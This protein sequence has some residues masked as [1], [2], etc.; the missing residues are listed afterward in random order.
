M[1]INARLLSILGLIAAAI[2]LGGCFS[3]PSTWD[4]VAPWSGGRWIPGPCDDDR[5]LPIMPCDAVVADEW[6]Q[7]TGSWQVVELVDIALQNNPLTRQSWQTAKAAAFTWRASQSTLYP[8]VALTEEILLE[9]LSGAAFINTNAGANGIVG[10]AGVITGGGI[11]TTTGSSS[12]STTPTYNQWVLST[13][14]FSYLMLDF[15]GRSATIESARQA[16]LAA[17]WT[18]NRN[19]Q[20]IILN[21]L[22]DYYQHVQAKALFLAREDDLRNSLETLRSAEAQ[23]EFGIARI[24]DVLL[25][26]SNFANAELLLEQQR[27]MVNTTLGQLANSIGMPANT[28]FDVKELPDEIKL[29]QLQDNVEQLIE[30]AKRER[31]DLAATEAQWKEAQEN[32]I[33]IWSSG[34]PT[35]NAG[36]TIQKTNNIHFPSLNSRFYSSSISLNVPIFSGFLY[37]NQTR[38]AVATAA[39]AYAAWRNQENTVMLDVVTSYYNYKT[40]IQTVKASEELYK[41]A[42]EAYN[43]SLYS[44]RNGVGTILDVL[45][46]LSSLSDARAQRIQARTQWI[47]SLTDVAYA[48]GQL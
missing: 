30:I 20:T 15:G 34:M 25:S 1:K 22:T 2:F 41:Y 3:D 9:K 46:A 4:E 47:T 6:S 32:A 45:A 18:H 7:H 39:A 5:D 26:R 38:S 40:A 44:Y 13:L 35:L 33:A 43:V 42:S 37:V 36:A 28:I 12:A 11:G 17:N 10:P 31:P 27:G 21:V 16:L 8:T 24:I 14:S 23:F 19:L 48:T 29:D